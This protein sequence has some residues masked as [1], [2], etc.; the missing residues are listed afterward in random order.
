MFRV[1]AAGMLVAIVRTCAALVHF[2]CLDNDVLST[3]LV[4]RRS[5][6]KRIPVGRHDLMRQE[7]CLDQLGD[8][9]AWCLSYHVLVIG[10]GLITTHSRPVGKLSVR[11]R[12]PVLSPQAR[13]PRPRDEVLQNVELEP[14]VTDD[15]KLF[16]AKD[17]HA[18][19]V[20]RDECGV[21]KLPWK[22]SQLHQFLVVVVVLPVELPFAILG[23]ALSRPHVFHLPRSCSLDNIVYQKQLAI[24]SNRV[25]QH[26][27]LPV[28]VRA[29]S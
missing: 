3:R 5:E 11:A 9:G 29:Q 4:K 20:D 19:V 16:N 13:I 21:L 25:L 15:R 24:S 2:A 26:T 1:C 10:D 18:A 14:S 6:H 17:I 8:L 28:L 12:L 27:C 23:I 22:R 7:A